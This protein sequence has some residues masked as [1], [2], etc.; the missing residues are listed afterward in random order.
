M[1][2][3]KKFISHI[4]LFLIILISNDTFLFATSGLFSINTQLM[5]LIALCTLFLGCSI[6]IPLKKNSRLILCVIAIF[7]SMLLTSVVNF[8]LS[9]GIVMM[10]LTII[11]SL[12]YLRIYPLREFVSIFMNI[13]YILAAYSI[14]VN[15]IYVS[16]ILAPSTVENIAGVP[17][18]SL[19]GCMFF[20][21]AGL[22]WPR[23]SSIFREPGMYMVFLN[24]AI[25]L[26]TI[27]SKQKNPLRLV[28]FIA[29]IL[30][31]MSTAGIVILGLNIV[32]MQLRGHKINLKPLIIF[33]IVGAVLLSLEALWYQLFNK[34]TMGEES[35]STLARVASF[36]V[37]AHIALDYP[38]GCSPSLFEDLYMSYSQKQFGISLS[39]SMMTNTVLMGL[40]VWGW[41][42]ALAFIGLI[43]RFAKSLSKSLL[44]AIIIFFIIVLS[45]S[46]E[47]M[48]YSLF[49]YILLFST[50]FNHDSD[51]CK[52]VGIR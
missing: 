49:I 9:G 38:F 24:I 26:N 29:A 23:A 12:L 13:M 5:F 43:I 34:V 20:R 18:D 19:L 16:G 22:I 39:L 36:I 14:V 46:N 27:T 37:P 33:A 51:N 3:H 28:V 25:M 32:F 50:Y 4:I 47:A 45:L 15:I 42:F 2:L 10:F 30:S 44:E 41:L 11:C 21:G 48:L 35:N 17:I 52:S 7:S 6:S 31:T 1:I 40:A 8:S